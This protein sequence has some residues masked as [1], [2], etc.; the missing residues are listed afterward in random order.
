MKYGRIALVESTV[1]E[2]R[3]YLLESLFQSRLFTNSINKLI[4]T[5]WS[6]QS[7]CYPYFNLHKGGRH[8]GVNT[9]E[10]HLPG[11]WLSGS[12]ITFWPF[13]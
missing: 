8:R 10:L 2:K 4:K 11:R 1:R 3:K 9:S 13:G 5:F 7:L 6:I 12:Q